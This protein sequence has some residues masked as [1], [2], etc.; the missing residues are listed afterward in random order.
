MHLSWMMFPKQRALFKC[1]DLS[2]RIK[3]PGYEPAVQ[4][5]SILNWAPAPDFYFALRLQAK[6]PAPA[7]QPWLADVRHVRN[8]TGTT[9]SQP[10]TGYANPSP[11]HELIRIARWSSPIYCVQRQNAVP[12]NWPRPDTGA[13]KASTGDFN[14]ILF[15]RKRIEH[16]KRN[17]RYN[18][19]WC[20]AVTMKETNSAE[21]RQQARHGFKPVTFFF[22]RAHLRHSFYHHDVNFAAT[23]RFRH[24]H[25]S[26]TRDIRDSGAWQHKLRASSAINHW[27]RFKLT[28]EG[29]VDETDVT[30]QPTHVRESTAAGPRAE[31]D[32]KSV[33]QIAPGDGTRTVCSANAE[34]AMF[35]PTRRT[36]FLGGTQARGQVWKFG[37]NAF[38]GGRIFVFVVCLKQIFLGVQ[39]INGENTWAQETEV[40]VKVETRTRKWR[41]TVRHKRNKKSTQ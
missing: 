5:R 10:S 12:E 23:A 35:D 36:S 30:A 32:R 28:S 7:P 19:K 17:A 13:A 20:R 22:K 37:G 41:S 3:I 15:T 8:V 33:R 6:C 27:I 40:D 14:L 9:V 31:R 26:L 24:R 39:W 1:W 34:R 11:L 2:P 29:E 21:T 4:L 16:L 38:L 18:G 25:L